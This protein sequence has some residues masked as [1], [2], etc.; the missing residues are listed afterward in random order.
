MT[1]AG[2]DGNDVEL[3]VAATPS[4]AVSQGSDTSVIGENVAL[5]ATL[6]SEL[7]TPAGTVTFL[8]NGVA[9]GTA[10]LANGIA[11]FNTSTLP[12]GSHTITASY[13]GGGP[14]F[15]SA[16]GPIT[17]SVGKDDTTTTIA[18]LHTPAVFG[19]A[20][21][22]I[23]CTPRLPA[24]VAVTGTFTI[25]DGARVVASGGIDGGTGHVVLPLLPVG[26]HAL[27]ASYSGAPS[28]AG[29]DSAPLLVEVGEAPTQV[30]AT[31]DGD[32]STT[33]GSVTLSILVTPLTSAPSIMT[34]TVTISEGGSVVSQQETTGSLTVTLKL[35]GG[36][37]QLSISYSGDANFL[38]SSQELEVD[39]KAPVP[40]RR[41][42][43]RH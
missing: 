31:S 42:A 37:H 24:A 32:E 27:I 34:G 39:S 26:T 36:H 38:P 4:A 40:A 5:S 11:T 7:G 20:E 9:I 43:A 22:R 25:R 19:A 8:D 18:V 23:V 14:F 15:G 33:D 16:S 2:G 13:A 28:F 35:A 21:F 41:R 6:T 1:Y 12:I 3:V 10:P 29:S 30:V 17:H